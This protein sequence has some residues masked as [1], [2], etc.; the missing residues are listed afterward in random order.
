MHLAVTKLPILGE[1]ENVIQQN[2]CPHIYITKMVENLKNEKTLPF[3][4]IKLHKHLR[5]EK[6]SLFILLNLISF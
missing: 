3:S 5:G 2:L 4:H 6:R 1:K